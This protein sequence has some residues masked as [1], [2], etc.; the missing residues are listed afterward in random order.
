M[1]KRKFPKLNPELCCYCG[2]CVSVCPSLALEL[3][4]TKIF[5]NKNKCIKCHSCIKVCP[6]G[7]LK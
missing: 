6:V 5:L 3:N 4:E 7:A 1:P 2:A